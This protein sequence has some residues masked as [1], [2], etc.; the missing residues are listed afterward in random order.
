MMLGPPAATSRNWIVP[1]PAG[2]RSAN[3]YFAPAVMVV[4]G[5]VVE[6]HAL[7]FGAAMVPCASSAPGLLALS[8][9]NPSTTCEAVFELER[10]TYSAFAVPVVVAVYWNA[11]A[12]PALLLSAPDSIFESPNR[13]VG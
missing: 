10:Y 3:Q 8:A 4:D 12:E 2:P 1:V 11:S 9:Y 7:A 6:F 5:I 13:S